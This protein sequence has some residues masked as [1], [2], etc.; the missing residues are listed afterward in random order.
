M[1]PIL[2]YTAY[3]ILTLVVL[4][5]LSLG[6][7]ITF[8]DPND[9]RDDI[10]RL[11]HDTTGIE[12]KLKGDLS[13]R[14]YPVLG[15]GASGVDLALQSDAPS[16]VTIGEFAVGVKLRPLL[17]KKIEIDELSLANVEAEFLVNEKGENNW[18]KKANDKDSKSADTADSKMTNIPDFYIPLVKLE[19][20]LVH[21]KNKTT[22]QNYT[23]EV[24]LL[25]LTDVDL[26]KRFPLEF[27]ARVSDADKLNVALEFS[28][29]VSL[30]LEKG[31]Y[32]LDGFILN[33][34][35]AGIFPRTAKVVV[36]G[37]V[38]FDQAQDRATLTFDKLNVANLSAHTAVNL[39]N[40]SKD[41]TFTG[42]LTSE[43]F[44]ARKL[45]D[46]LGIVLPEMASNDALRKVKINVPFSGTN[47]TAD[48]NSFSIHVDDS[49]FS[50]DVSVTDFA[51][52][53]LHFSVVLDKLNADQYLPPSADN[54]VPVAVVNKNTAAA[55]LM[56][57]EALRDLNLQGTIQASEVTFKTIPVR[58]I[59]LAI[60]AQNGLVSVTDIGAKAMQGTLAGSVTLDA[61]KTEP[62]IKTLL[63]VKDIEINQ[64]LQPFTKVQ[65]LSGRT[66]FQVD[67]STQG[68]NVE[69]LL[70][71]ALGQVNVS[72]AD[73]LLHGV[74]LNQMALDA[75]KHKLGDFT[76]LY[77]DY[78]QKLPKALKSDTQIK[79]LLANM[80][81]EKGHLIM[82]DLHADTGQGSISAVGDI[83]LIKK[84]FDYRFGIVLEAL[85]GNKYLKGL[86]WPIHCRG[87]L[88]LSVTEW[89]RPDSNAVATLFEQAAAQALRDKGSKA[90]ADKL[91]LDTENEKK[92][93]EE[94]RLKAKAEEDKAK[95]NVN[96]A[97][98]KKLDKLL[99]R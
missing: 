76:A 25:S 72:M 4:M 48:V 41:I 24:P 39:A 44:D 84:G 77:P 68:N 18:Q 27:N 59:G 19:H 60:K 32:R 98:S 36:A 30:Q 67:T 66:N 8:V 65:L 75:V 7:L 49:T 51:T 97:L 29:S 69:A 91:G 99:N 81:M 86:Q 54:K 79:N 16:L 92:A 26:R 64:F 12:L 43:Y 42:T 21:Y 31:L 22:V 96:D 11:V 53:A 95:Q 52:Q 14:I 17:S 90:V 62:L 10:S 34:D 71:Q 47:K 56:P 74:N 58:D 55:D 78:E 93:K 73:T 80:K 2:K 45:T 57:V 33:A 15:F 94:L 6:L 50:G 20:V 83:D 1:N 9:Y 40:V 46:S 37:D 3:A 5:V 61:R 35:I 82:P 85:S 23:I 13:W 88:G 38:L 63:T 70:Q 87:E 89:C 28:S